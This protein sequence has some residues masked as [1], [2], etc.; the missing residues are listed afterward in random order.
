MV[1]GILS[2]ADLARYTIDVGQAKVAK[3]NKSILISA[4]FSG[5]FIAFAALASLGATYGLYSN[6]GLANPDIL[7]IDTYGLAK[8]FQ[9]I[10]FSAGLMFIIFLGTDLFTGNVLIAMSVFDKKVKL[11]KMFSNL[12]L[13]FIGNLI[14]A[15]IVGVLVYKSGVFGWSNELYAKVLNKTIVAKSNLDFS[16]A[17][18]S[19]ILC[20]WLVCAIV[21]ATY[22]VKDTTSKL[23]IIGSGILLFVVGG[24]EHV[25]ANM[26]YYAGALLQKDFPSI[27]DTIVNNIIPVT[28]GNIFGGAI[29]VA[30]G[31]YYM[32]KEKM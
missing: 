21:L 23:L 20:N 4:I 1:N 12:G 24:Y 18:F 27:V 17:L 25:I 3:S 2:P 9:G 26:G 10:I 15:L 6:P 19:G 28:I 32:V 8:F 22:A 13:V 7:G 29:F 31:Y 14:G 30:G 11:R 16:T 5:S